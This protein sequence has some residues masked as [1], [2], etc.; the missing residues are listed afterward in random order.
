[1]SDEA[2]IDSSALVAIGLGESGGEALAGLLDRFASLISSNLLEAELR[3]AF[4]REGLTE[5]P[6]SLPQVNWVLPN[7]ALSQEIQRVLAAGYLRGADLWHLA[8]ALY[9]SPNPGDVTFVSL[10]AQQ[11]KVASLLGFPVAPAI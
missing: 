3:S 9:T 11:R 2:Y 7:R 10:D 1:V 5:E 4:R 6:M 8:T